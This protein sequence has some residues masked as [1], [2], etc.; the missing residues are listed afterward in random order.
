[1]KTNQKLSFSKELKRPIKVSKKG[2]E[3]I[4]FIA[5]KGNT[6]KRNA[7]AKE[8]GANYGPYCY[9]LTKR[10]LLVREQKEDGIYFSLN[11]EQPSK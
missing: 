9:H 3:L 1:M 6:V 11:L 2:Q 10:S 5:K 8:L 4:E 7:I